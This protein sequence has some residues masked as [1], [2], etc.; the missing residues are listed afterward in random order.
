ME[1]PPVQGITHNPLQPVQVEKRRTSASHLNLIN[2]QD[3]L[4]VEA[5]PSENW[6]AW[7]YSGPVTKK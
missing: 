3:H 5:V 1:N 7:N 2:P 4:F 6:N